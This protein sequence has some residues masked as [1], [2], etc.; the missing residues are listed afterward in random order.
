MSGIL[1]AK[2]DRLF[3]DG[4]GRISAIKKCLKT[5]PEL[6]QH[7]LDVKVI[8]VPTATVRESAAFASQVFSDFH[9][10]VTKPN[11][12]QNI[13]FDSEASLSR[14]A[15]E[16]L[17]ITKNLGVNFDEAIAVNGKIKHGQ[18]YTLANMTDFISI[19][20]GEKN[21]DKINAL[22]DKED[23]YNLYLAL[24]SEY[25]L[26]LYKHL[27]LGQIQLIEKKTDWKKALDS[28]VLTCAIGLKALAFFGRSLIEDA[29]INEKTSLNLSPLLA[30]AKMPINERGDK[31]W[32]QNEIYQHIE[33]KLKI[34]RASEKRMARLMC[35]HSRV[36]PC[37][38]LV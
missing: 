15:K 26:G 1:P 36:L 21:K 10:R 33:G 14:F 32:L 7:H 17:E 29:L 31:L 3:I 28:C 16:L 18:L 6:A 30:I 11:P 19:M 25:I 24:I 8:V 20:V 13:F 37:R 2:A 22:L 9:K 5:N 27:P 23:N 38:E 34:V 35:N 4:Q 12:S